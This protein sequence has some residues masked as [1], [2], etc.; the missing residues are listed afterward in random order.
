MSKSQ[1]ALSGIRVIEFAGEI[2]SYTG[3]LFANLGAEVIQIEPIEGSPVR[4]AAPFYQDIPGKERSLQF[5]YQNTN[6]KSIVLD[7]EKEQGRE[8]FLN[9]VKTADLLLESFPPVYL[10]KLNLGYDQLSALNPRLVY[11]SVTGYGQNGPYRDYPWSDITAMAMGGLLYLAAEGVDLPVRAPD[12]QAYMMGSLHAAAG[13]MLALLEAE[14]S[15]RGQ[16]LDI[17]LQECVAGSLENAIQFYDLEGVTRRAIG[18]QEA[19]FGFYPCQDGDVY[20]CG[21]MGNNVN[22]WNALVDWL[23]EHK[24]EG[25]DI[26]A[27]D[28]WKTP[29]FRKTAEAKQRFNEI[30]IP[31]AMKHKK[32]YLFENG[33][34]QRVTIAPVNNAKDIC[35]DSHVQYRKFM[36]DYFSESLGG[37]VFMP[38][39]PFRMSLTPWQLGAEPPK[40]GQHTA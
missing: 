8:V 39:A 11:T 3:K 12:N 29:Q 22:L 17:S 34:D 13:S 37:Q 1:G 32:K 2:G 19:G 25:A 24:V 16:Y 27:H 14:E 20:L 5:I 33:Q 30:F 38:G 40:L 18:S 10:K 7:I 23:L 9:L 28:E 26:L 15:G 6:K 4:R 36:V 21:G 35:E 31:F